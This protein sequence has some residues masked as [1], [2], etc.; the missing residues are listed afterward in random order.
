MAAAACPAQQQ[1]PPSAARPPPAVAAGAPGRGRKIYTTPFAFAPTAA[2]AALTTLF[3]SRG[4]LRL[5][6][7]LRAAACNL[8]ALGFGRRRRP[9]IA[10]S[11][12]THTCNSDAIP[13]SPPY[14]LPA[15]TCLAL[16]SSSYP[17]A[18][19]RRA[20]VQRTSTAAPWCHRT[21]HSCCALL[22]TRTVLQ[23]AYTIT[24]CSF[25]ILQPHADLSM[26]A[27]SPTYA[28]QLATPALYTCPPCRCPDIP[29]PPAH[30]ALPLLL[31]LFLMRLSRH[32]CSSCTTGHNLYRPSMRRCDRHR[33]HRRQGRRRGD[34]DDKGGGRGGHRATA[35]GGAAMDEFGKRRRRT[36]GDGRGGTLHRQFFCAIPACRRYR[37][38][39]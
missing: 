37:R 27:A 14:F 36:G 35:A 10:L 39:A 30:H 20:T 34:D 15:T 25:S 2:M 21:S 19:D 3:L 38:A 32:T 13:A 18:Y 29:L 4:A 33:N 28:R 1:H 17:P 7:R 6:C 24:T 11:T 8:F 31:I 12:A 26:A 16:S 5:P 23:P 22:P 9:A